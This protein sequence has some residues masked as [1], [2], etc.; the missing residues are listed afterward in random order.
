M[1]VIDLLVELNNFN[2]GKVADLPKKIKMYGNIYELKKDG[3]DDHYYYDGN[4]HSLLKDLDDTC[5]LNHEIE[6]IEE[7]NKIEKLDTGII[8]TKDILE[9][10]LI[11]NKIHADY[12]YTINKIIDKLNKM[13]E[14]K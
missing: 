9:L 12:D 4:V 2:N 1:R 14:N 10:E 13:E 6:V 8:D 3:L 11:I 7:D 5:D